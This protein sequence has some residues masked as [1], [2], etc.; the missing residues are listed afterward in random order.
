MSYFCRLFVYS[1]RRIIRLFCLIFSNLQSIKY[2]DKK[3]IYDI[4]LSLEVFERICGDKRGSSS[5][6]PDDVVG[7][8]CDSLKVNKIILSLE[9]YKADFFGA[10]L[11]T[12]KSNLTLVY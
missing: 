8:A 5:P 4:S 2:S 6:S 12:K 9:L 3:L 10:D 7:P 11:I 1:F